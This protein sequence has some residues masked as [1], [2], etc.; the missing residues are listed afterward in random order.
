MVFKGEHL[1]KRLA[2][3]AQGGEG[4][5]TVAGVLDL[6]QEPRDVA[7]GDPDVDDLQGGLNSQLMLLLLA[8]IIG[9]DEGV[10]ARRVHPSNVV[11][12]VLDQFD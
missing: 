11:V 4:T 5:G 6:D 10:I 7:F 8:G 3:H 9:R 2:K 12:A 1:V